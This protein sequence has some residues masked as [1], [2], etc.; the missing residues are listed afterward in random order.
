MAKR[1][2]RTGTRKSNLNRRRKGFSAV[3]LPWFKRFGV[4]VASITLVLWLGAW[5]FLSDANENLGRF[6]GNKTIQQTADLGFRVEN[7]LVEGR[8]HTDPE[9]IMALVNMEEGDPLFAFDPASAK[10]Q[11]E[12]ITWVENAKV[13]RR[14]PDTIHIQLTE[15]TPIALWQHNSRLRLLD[16]HGE[17]ITANSIDDC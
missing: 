2:T 4:I 1:K 15:R 16:Q 3:F 5:F 10:D 6:I 17:I 12:K 9:I 11:I 14:W 8:N 7:I 13:S